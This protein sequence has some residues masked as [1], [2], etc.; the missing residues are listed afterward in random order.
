MAM[1][2]IVSL[3]LLLEITNFLLELLELLFESLDPLLGVGVLVT[4]F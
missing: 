3:Q 4:R 1:W 2:M